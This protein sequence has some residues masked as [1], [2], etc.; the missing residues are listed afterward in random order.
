MVSLLALQHQL[1]LSWVVSLNLLQDDLPLLLQV[2]LMLLPLFDLVLL[3]VGPLHGVVELTLVRV[4]EAV[5]HKDLVEVRPAAVCRHPKHKALVT[6][7]ADLFG[8]VALDVLQQIRQVVHG[9]PLLRS[10]ND[11]HST[12]G[13]SHHVHRILVEEGEVS[14]VLGGGFKGS[15]FAQIALAFESCRRH[16]SGLELL[17]SLVVV[18]RELANLLEHLNLLSLRQLLVG[19]EK[20]LV[21]INGIEI[22]SELLQLS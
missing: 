5:R 2:E 9:L 19:D 15:C 20:Q 22:V 8:A 7:E 18:L 3:I 6:V 17:Q 13:T 1:V 11:D 10:L 12:L 4:E 21:L 16:N 14:Q